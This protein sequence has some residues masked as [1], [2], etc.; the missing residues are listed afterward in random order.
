ME[1]LREEF[2]RSPDRDE[3]GGGGERRVR[4]PQARPLDV[5]SKYGE[6]AR[7]RSRLAVSNREGQ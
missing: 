7:Q 2:G 5:S 1:R 6:P 4:I 3:D